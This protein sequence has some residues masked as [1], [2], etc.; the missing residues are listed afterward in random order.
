[1]MVF[2]SA[3]D[4]LVRAGTII[5]VPVQMKLHDTIIIVDGAAIVEIIISGMDVEDINIRQWSVVTGLMHGGFMTCT[6]MLGNG[7]LTGG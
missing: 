5:R 2:G 4:R 3:M 7:A 1:M 6:A